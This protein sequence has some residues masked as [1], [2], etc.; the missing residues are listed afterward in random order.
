MD[1][2]ESISDSIVYG[3]LLQNPVQFPIFII[4]D[5]TGFWTVLLIAVSYAT[6]C[7]NTVSWRLKSSMQPAQTSS[8]LLVQ[9]PAL[10]VSFRF[11]LQV[12]APML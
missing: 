2:V 9:D 1:I 10:S 7:A 6:D 11:K 4:S 12:L 5:P 8:S 3:F